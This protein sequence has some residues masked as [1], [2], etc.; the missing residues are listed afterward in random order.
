MKALLPIFNNECANEV[1]IVLSC[2]S[3]L[4]VGVLQKQRDKGDDSSSVADA[5][6]TGTE[7]D[8][9]VEKDAK[10]KGEGGESS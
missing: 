6:E 10:D 8:R 4:Y 7:R 2:H 1:I 3:Y 9:V 5:S